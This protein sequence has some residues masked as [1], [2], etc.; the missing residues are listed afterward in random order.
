MSRMNLRE[1]IAHE[2]EKLGE[3]DLKLALAFVSALASLDRQAETTELFR[4]M[5]EL[6]KPADPATQRFR[7]VLIRLMQELGEL[8]DPVTQRF[9][10]ALLRHIRE[11][12]KWPD[13]VTLRAIVALWTARAIAKADGITDEDVLEEIQAYRA[14]TALS[15]S[16]Y[17]TQRSQSLGLG[18]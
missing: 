9:V 5:Q 15:T 12:G 13:P 3:G 17:S 14:S 16:T 1:A 11:H 10:E 6:G 8:D 4:Q 7:E 18:Q 2:L